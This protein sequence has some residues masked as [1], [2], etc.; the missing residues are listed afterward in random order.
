MFTFPIDCSS[1][2]YIINYY[3]IIIIIILNNSIT[4][5]INYKNILVLYKINTQGIYFKTIIIFRYISKLL[6]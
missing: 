6:I 1:K 5:I 3:I 4:I 2:I